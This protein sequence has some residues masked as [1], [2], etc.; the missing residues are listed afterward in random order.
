M[1]WKT[2]WS[3]SWVCILDARACRHSLAKKP[4]ENNT[5]DITI[6]GTAKLTFFTNF[7]LSVKEQP[8][9]FRPRYQFIIFW[10]IVNNQKNRL[11][12]TVF[13][14]E[15]PND[16]YGKKDDSLIS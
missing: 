9:I 6:Q 3:T 11:Q 4:N 2:R 12:K 1:Q 5:H 8:K 15:R 7:S 13:Q 14:E 16:G 10:L